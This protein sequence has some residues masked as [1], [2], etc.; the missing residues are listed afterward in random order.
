M[1]CMMRRVV[2]LVLPFLV[3]LSCGREVEGPAAAF[4]VQLPALT[5]EQVAIADFAGEVV[6]VDFWA[7]WCVPCRLQAEIFHDLQ[8]EFAGQE[9]RFLAV[10]VAEEEAI[11]EK[12]VASHPFGY[13]VLT[14]TDESVTGPL[15]V[16][17]LPTVMVVGRDGEMKYLQT[18]ISGRD[19]LGEVLREAL[20]EKG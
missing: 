15:G 7:T 14:D 13:P 18:G 11:V 9:V 5:G 12:F 19:Q 2:L 20:A 6:A 3:A 10:S 1:E 4:A 8:T 17:A 16:F